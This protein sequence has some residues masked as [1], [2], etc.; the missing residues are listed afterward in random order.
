[1]RERRKKENFYFYE[2]KVAN[3]HRKCRGTKDELSTEI[4]H[5]RSFSL[6]CRDIVESFS[7]GSIFPETDLTHFPFIRRLYQ[8]RKEAQVL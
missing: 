4:S 1:M 7:D 2:L 3:V 8:W 5:F 6:S